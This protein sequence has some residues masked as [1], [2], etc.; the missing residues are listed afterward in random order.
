MQNQDNH[1][2]D[3]FRRAAE[4]YPLKTSESNW[5]DIAPLLT[6]NS[7]TTA[8]AGKTSANKYVKRL[9]PLLLLLIAG[10][11]STLFFLNNK[12]EKSNYDSGKITQEEKLVSEEN[13]AAVSTIQN[14]RVKEVNYPINIISDNIIHPAKKDKLINP[15]L[16]EIERNGPIKNS[17]TSVDKISNNT[18]KEIADKNSKEEIKAVKE[19]PSI[20]TI[21][22]NESSLVETKQTAN[23]LIEKE[24]K[25][26][27]A[28]IPVIKN[29]IQKQK[30]LYAG[31]IVG[32]GFSE[33]KNQGFTKAGLEAGVRAGYRFNNK[34]S[35]ETGLFFAHKYYYSDGKY[36]SMNK[37]SAAMPAGMQ[38]LSLNGRSTVVQ[39][40]VKLKYNFILKNNA[41]FF[42]TAGLTSY[43]MTKEK[44]NYLALINGNKQNITSTYKQANRYF[45][46]A[47]DLSIGY[48]FNIQKNRSL[49]IEPYL[50]IPLKGIGVGIMPVTSTGLHIG[51]TFFK[52]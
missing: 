8:V 4:G 52:H 40:P 22:K 19:T 23:T 16:K 9:L 1:M 5:D 14:K 41:N 50:Q 34:L 11:A 30:G 17:I 45:A 36:F 7:F 43:I 44:N 49:R 48:E 39:I 51:Y 42:S 38:V 24:N 12:K 20:L 3:L 29:K 32:T 6:G 21:T 13:T 26:A 46:A 31:I 2:D 18:A 15:V 10:G 25:M 33:V 27:V 35:I 28:T 37:I 47:I